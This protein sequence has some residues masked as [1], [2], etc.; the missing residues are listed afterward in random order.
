MATVATPP[1]TIWSQHVQPRSVLLASVDPAS[2]RSLR[3]ALTGIR[4]QV[5]EAGGAA[6]ALA[7]LERRPTEVLVLD[8]WLPDIEVNEFAAIIAERFPALEVLRATGEPFSKAARSSR[9][10]ELLVVLREAARQLASTSRSGPKS[11][12]RARAFSQENAGTFRSEDAPTLAER[13]ALGSSPLPGMIG[14][15]AAMRELARLV[16]LVAPRNT[17]VLIEG[18][19]GS[20]KEVVAQALHTLSHRAEQTF[21][22]LNCAAIPEALLE[23]EL[24]GHTRGAFTG[25]T[26]SRTGRVEA[27]D[28]G[29][30]FLDEIGE[31]PLALQAK[32]LRFLEC[33]EIQRVGDNGVTNVNVRVIAATHQP[34]EQR[35][36]DGTF[37]LDLYHRLAVFP[38]EVPSLQERLDDLPALAE[39]FLDRFSQVSGRKRLTPDALEELLSHRWPGNVRELMHVLERG[40]ILSSESPTIERTHIR[41]RR[42]PRD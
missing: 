1:A 29:T 2:L 3:D 5:R 23:A 42:R 30:L 4:W 21:A 19:T 12:S 16:R 26:Q 34:L 36:S 22:V 15:S 31:M 39:H 38:V 13:E 7:E 28:G 32:M 17:T 27:A 37:R 20:G 8:H 6:E 35:S 25:A 11:S 14:E 18:P 9:R 33:G 24:F 41:L 10:S 40:V